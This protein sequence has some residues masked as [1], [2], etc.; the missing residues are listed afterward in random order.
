MG[1][2]GNYYKEVKVCPRCYHVYAILDRARDVLRAFPPLPEPA[3][4]VA[5]AGST[6][7]VMEDLGL[8]G[9][10]DKELV[11]DLR[12]GVA[13]CTCTRTRALRGVCACVCAPFGVCAVAPVAG[14]T[15]GACF[16]GFQANPPP[17]DSPHSF[18]PPA[19]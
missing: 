14:C 1:G 12:W 7:P 6:G 2:A 15:C 11:R 13:R 9:F 16:G 8:G 5:H 19:Q 18:T 17:L 10:I 4:G 3:G